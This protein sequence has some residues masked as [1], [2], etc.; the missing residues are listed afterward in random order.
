MNTLPALVLSAAF[1]LGAA[2][3]EDS[4]AK[5]AAKFKGSHML[6]CGD[7]SVEVMDPND[8]GRYYRGVR[9]TPVAA[10]IRATL[11]GEEFLMFETEHDPL[12]AAAGLFA[13]FDLVNS[14]PGFDEAK[15]GDAFVKIGVG[16]LKKNTP[17]YTFYKPYEVVRPARTE[18][19]WKDSAVVF[20]QVCEAVNGYGYE[21]EA[22]LI[23]GVDR[24]DINWSLK[25]TGDKPFETQ[26]YAHNCFSFNKQ[27]VG[28][29]Y[30]VDFPYDFTA[31]GLQPEQKQVG[32]RLDFMAEI[33]KAVNIKVD[34][35]T[36]YDGPNTLSARHLKSGHEVTCL[37]SLPGAR[38]MVHAAKVYLCP[39]QFI[40]I[41]LKPG[42]SAT[43]S[44]QYV[45]T[46]KP[47]L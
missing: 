15:D 24:I 23:V 14:P 3:A 29:D 18:A 32:R 41:R 30:V 35:P 12:Q 37:T 9:F 1:A 40:T 16:A 20:R 17:S 38:T 21:L 34:S 33:P 4:A 39:E 43:W 28:P 25:N 2:T 45:F 11:D 6:R 46:F 7:L 36:G 44:R 5:M 22:A 26:Q 13:E 19:I 31:D 27:P 8:A 47:K 10:V 42:E